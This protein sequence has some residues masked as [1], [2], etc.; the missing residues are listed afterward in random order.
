MVIV[1]VIPAAGYAMR[2]QPLA[3][4]KEMLRV[5]GRPVMDYLVDRLRAGGCTELRVVTRPEKRDVIA[6][7]EQLGARVVLSYPRTVSASLV[8]GMDGLSN[9]D[10]VLIGF[11]DSLWE[12]QDGYRRLVG[13][14][15]DRC[16]AALGLFRIGTSDLK[17]SDVVVLAGDDWRIAGIDIKPAE[18]RSEWTWGC[19]AV[20]ARTLG[21]LGQTEW[22]GEYFDSLCREGSDVCGIP[23]SDVWLDVGTE[24]ALNRANSIFSQMKP[25]AQ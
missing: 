14:L 25:E 11:P 9:D 10:V 15:E 1:G 16:D 24:A 4:S 18:P 3:G 2:L 19:A 20:Y 12:P 7:A 5:G 6:Y 21:G 13:A 22:P 23:L 17:R 8:A